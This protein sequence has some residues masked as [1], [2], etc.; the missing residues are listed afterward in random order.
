MIIIGSYAMTYLANQ[1]SLYKLIRSPRDIDFIGTIDEYERLL[2]VTTHCSSAFPISDNKFVIERTTYPLHIEVEIA[3]RGSTAAELLK[4]IKENNFIVGKAELQYNS[5]SYANLDVLYALKMS[6]RYLKNS[7][8]F[9]K[10]MRDIFDLREVGTDKINPLLLDWFK[11]REKETYNYKHPNLNQKKSEFFNGDGITYIYD[12][13]SIHESIKLYS[14]PAY[15]YF[16]EPDEEVKTSKEMFFKCTEEI[17]L[18]S[19]YEEAC[20]LALERSQIPFNFEPHPYKS[21]QKALQKVCT[22]ITSGWW[23]EF[24]WDH[25]YKVKSLYDDTYVSRFQAAIKNGIVKPYEQPVKLHR[26]EDMEFEI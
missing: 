22:S 26:K 9:A 16:K 7:P 5:A 13:D 24:A 6:H 3:W 25:Y 2:S 23:R 15:D 10:T 12:H 20:V 11:R 21:F 18:A 1:K 4:I 14:K 19:V 17:Q 8:H